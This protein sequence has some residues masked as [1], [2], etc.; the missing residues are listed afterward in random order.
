VLVCLIYQLSFTQSYRLGSSCWTSLI[1]VSSNLNVATSKALNTISIFPRLISSSSKSSSRMLHF[2]TDL[3]GQS[4]TMRPWLNP[5]R[6]SYMRTITLL[7]L[8][9]ENLS[10]LCQYR[11]S[12]NVLIWMRGSG[13]YVLQA[14]GNI[15]IVFAAL[16]RVKNEGWRADKTNWRNTPTMTSRE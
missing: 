15:I 6:L 10:G 14:P 11:D 8:R 12:N 4:V 3:I 9:S 5:P 1:W 2:H 13:K 16:H 7:L